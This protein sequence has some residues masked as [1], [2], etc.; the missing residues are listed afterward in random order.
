MQDILVS[1]KV[2]QKAM[3]DREARLIDLRD[4]NAYQSG[5]VRGAQN[6][7]YDSFE[8]WMRG[9]K[10]SLELYLYCERGNQSLEAARYARGQG[11]NAYSIAGGIDA[12]EH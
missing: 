5:H 6:V 9:Q 4:T 2:A 12:F 10:R 8:G 1:W 7:P 11:R 3:A